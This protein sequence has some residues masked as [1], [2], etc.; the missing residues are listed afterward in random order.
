MTRRALVEALRG[1]AHRSLNDGGG[2]VV[3]IA[4]YVVIVGT[5]S[6]LWRVAVARQRR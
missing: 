4:F 3:A 5:L 2:L 1:S 6:G